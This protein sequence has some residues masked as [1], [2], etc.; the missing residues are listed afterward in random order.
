MYPVGAAD[1]FDQIFRAR[2]LAHYNLNPFTTLPNNIAGDPLQ[3]YVAWRGDP[4]PYGPMWEALAAGVSKL[5][6]DS[7][8]RNLILF[9]LLVTAAY[10][11]S[12]ALTYGILRAIKP[13]IHLALFVS[14]LN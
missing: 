11:I 4:S 2:L 9:K 7:L 5:A 13:D 12:I 6:G 14:S 8:W 1:I 3:Q 10:G